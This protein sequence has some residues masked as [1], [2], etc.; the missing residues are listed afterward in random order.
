M[1]W[2]CHKWVYIPVSLRWPLI[3]LTMHASPPSTRE[4]NLYIQDKSAEVEKTQ[5]LHTNHILCRVFCQ[6]V[7]TINFPGLEHVNHSG[8][9]HLVTQ[10]N[11]HDDTLYIMYTNTCTHTHPCTHTRSS[12]LPPTHHTPIHWLGWRP[13]IHHHMSVYL[14]NGFH[15]ELYQLIFH[16]LQDNK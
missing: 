13:I 16:N 14:Y 10:E 15:V 9:L 3:H 5:N 2:I 1:L 11:Q 12:P 8:M 7:L 6:H 4:N